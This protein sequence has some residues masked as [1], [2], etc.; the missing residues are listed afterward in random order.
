MIL[1][2]IVKMKLKM[3]MI[4]DYN[5]KFK[6]KL[7]YNLYKNIKTFMNVKETPDNNL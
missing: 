4:I 3:N 5:I 7:T 6:V 2:Y 1:N